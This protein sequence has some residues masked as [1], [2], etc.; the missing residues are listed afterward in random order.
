MVITYEVDEDRIETLEVDGRELPY[1]E[2]HRQQPAVKLVLNGEEYALVKTFPLRGYAPALL[3]QVREL[4]AEGK[5]VLVAFF[6]PGRN[7]P[8]SHHWER[9]YLYATGVRP[10]GMGKA[11]GA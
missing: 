5:K 8:T 2:F 6:P 3:R 11:P 4:E 1:V 9:L 7:F 10:I